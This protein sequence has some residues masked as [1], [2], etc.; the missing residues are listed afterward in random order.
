MA[1]RQMQVSVFKA[2]CIAAVREVDK[3]GSALVITL[4]GKPLVTVEPIRK[5]RTLGALR[6]EADVR[7]DL[8]RATF[9]GEWE[10]NR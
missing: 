5:T 6:G 7:C 3:S 4:R 9:A 2:Q 1:K 10:M 8:V